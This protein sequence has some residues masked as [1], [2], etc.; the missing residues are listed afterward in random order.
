MPTNAPVDFHGIITEEVRTR[1]RA[2]RLQLGL[3]REDLARLLKVN[4]MTISKWETGGS[5]RCIK[6]LIAPLSDF[7]NG[8]LVPDTLNPVSKELYKDIPEDFLLCMEQIVRIYEL[9][10]ETSPLRKMVLERLDNIA[11][12][13][14]NEDASA[15][16]NASDRPDARP[17][18]PV[19]PTEAQSRS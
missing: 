6:A 12:E 13:A 17:S 2:R 8:R 9:S 10:A 15:P 3:S 5:T 4:R 19:P 18:C 7:L 16:V 1:L 14:E 11:D